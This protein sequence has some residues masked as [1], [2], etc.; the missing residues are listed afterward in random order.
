M[1]PTRLALII[2][3]LLSN[4]SCS[5]EC[6]RCDLYS[7]PNLPT[8][9]LSFSPPRQ[10][11]VWYGTRTGTVGGPQQT[12]GGVISSAQ[13]SASRSG[14]RP[15]WQPMTSSG[16][17]KG[18]QGSN[19]PTYLSPQQQQ[20]IGR[21]NGT[22]A[23]QYQPLNQATGG[24]NGANNGYQTV[25]VTGYSQS[26]TGYGPISN[27]IT[28]P[29]VVQTPQGVRGESQQA[30]NSQYNGA[31]D[32]LPYQ[33]PSPNMGGQIQGTSFPQQPQRDDQTGQTRTY[34]VTAT[35]N[36]AQRLA[37][38][39]STGPT[40]T[41]ASP[42]FTQAPYSQSNV[43]VQGVFPTAPISIYPVQSP[44]TISG[45]QGYTSSAS[46][47]SYTTTPFPYGST[48]NPNQW[49]T[50][51]QN[52]NQWL[53]SQGVINPSQ[54][55]YG[56]TTTQ[57]E[58]TY[59]GS[60]VG[61]EQFFTTY[62]PNGFQ[63]QSQSSSSWFP[64][65]SQSVQYTNQY[66]RGS[67]QSTMYGST[68]PTPYNPSTTPMPTAGFTSPS[69]QST[70][71]FQTN[72]PQSSSSSPT[73]SWSTSGF[74]TSS[75]PPTQYGQTGGPSGQSQSSSMGFTSPTQ[76]NPSTTQMPT[77]GF[78]SSSQQPPYDYQTDRPSSPSSSSSPS[79]STSGFAT[80]STPPVQYDQT[81]GP[82]GQYQSSSVGL[83]SPTQQP[84]YG[85]QTSG[86]ET[87][88]QPYSNSIFSS[89]QSTPLPYQTTGAQGQALTSS[90]SGFTSSTQSPYATARSDTNGLYGQNAA[91]QFV[92][93]TAQ[94]PYS[95]PR[96]TD[97]T[98]RQFNSNEPLNVQ[99]G[100][101]NIIPGNSQFFDVPANNTPTPKATLISTILAIALVNVLL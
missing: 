1:N 71:D 66:D 21:Q 11:V 94:L 47:M 7:P 22:G 46:G 24:Y 10:V 53:T 67:T 33:S 40:Q 13:D 20:G 36:D 19:L 74:S 89:T 54:G 80:S 88:T 39:S 77:V 2:A 37:G 99:R 63:G 17:Q 3:L 62:Q 50:S 60:S 34:Q 95:S 69:L 56:T 45:T 14:I 18:L 81:G 9:C 49:P 92:E 98:T 70:Y 31:N 6:T 35:Y 61:S 72:G 93:P 52:P 16:Y 82:S 85:Y 15:Q 43:P 86:Q 23:I 64:S 32:Y 12:A 73:S 55:L 4:T 38:S 25:T 68:S 91:G 44:T 5:L 101:S 8:C 84:P 30:W 65:S 78:T 48:Q 29:S 87:R 97:G 79:W 76:Y 96:P 83:T 58:S 100:S 26:G 90:P 51:T 41:T 42:P 59:P 57:F 75:S 28:N 27:Q